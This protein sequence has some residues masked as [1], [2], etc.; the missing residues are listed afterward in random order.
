MPPLAAG[1]YTAL[2]LPGTPILILADGGWSV[3]TS[4]LG[5][6][7]L[8]RTSTPLERLQIE[9][10][11][12]LPRDVCGSLWPYVATNTTPEQQFEAWARANKGLRLS[13]ALPWNVGGEGGRLLAATEYDVSVVAQYACQ[14]TVPPSVAV[15]PISSGIMF[16]AGERMR[17]EV[18]SSNDKLIL[19]LIEAP[20]VTEFDTFE[21]L[22]EQVLDSWAWP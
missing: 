6:L 12:S 17:L 14:S 22:A 19:M 16:Y 15:D 8:D 7:F 4:D 5:D 10:I 3:Q 11:Y 2:E 1:S 18:A 13:A 9:W 21:P 20:S